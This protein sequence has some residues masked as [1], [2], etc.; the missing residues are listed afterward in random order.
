M[1]QMTQNDQTNAAC[2]RDPRDIPRRHR[3]GS[4]LWAPSCGLRRAPSSERRSASGAAARW[5]IDDATGFAAA[6]GVPTMNLGWASGTSG[7]TFW[8]GIRDFV[9]WPRKF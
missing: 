4:T 5:A 2:M 8:E 7:V 9:Y 3:C 6:I 1:A